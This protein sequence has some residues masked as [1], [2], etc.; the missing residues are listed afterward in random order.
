MSVEI[1]Y[2]K[3]GK[4]FQEVINQLFILQIKNTATQTEKGTKH[5]E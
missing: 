5:Y 3:T 2:N 1:V 4:T